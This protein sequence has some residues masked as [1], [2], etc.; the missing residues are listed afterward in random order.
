ML[1]P[2]EMQRDSN[3]LLAT[4]FTDVPD[5]GSIGSTEEEALGMALDA[6][7][8]A[9]G[10]CF[11]DRCRVPLPSRPRQG[12]KTVCLPALESAKVLLHNEMME[13]GIQIADLA[14]RLDVARPYIECIFDIKHKTRIEAVE[15]A[16]HALGRC[17]KVQVVASANDS[18]AQAE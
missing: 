5:V 7:L 9:I 8:V 18:K 13:Q 6:L 17:L 14:R 12:Q 10:I 16:L 3:G 2:I 1:Y 11:Q 15:A 4:S